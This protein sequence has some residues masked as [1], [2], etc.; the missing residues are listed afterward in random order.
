VKLPDIQGSSRIALGILLIAV[1]A[2][3]DWSVDLNLSFGFLYLFPMLLLGT[4][5]TRWQVVI[6]A[7]V[8][9]GLSDVFDPF[10]FHV[11]VSGPQDILVF[12][13]L[14]GTG[15]FSY[16]VTRSRRREMENLRRVEAEATARRQAEEQLEFIIESSPA[17]ILTI[18]SDA[19]VLRANSAAHRLLGIAF[20]ALPGRLI[21]RYL[22]A[23]SRVPFSGS[24][25]QNFRTEMQ[26]RGER[27]DGAVFLANVFFSTYTT[28]AGPRLAALIVDASE[29]LREREEASLEQMMAGSRIL[30]GAVSHEVRN[31]CGAIAVI[32]ENL[33]RSGRLQANKD[34]EALG[35]LVET[36]N[37]IASLELKQSASVA[38]IGGIDLLETLDD[39]RIVLEP[40][41]REAGI[42]VEWEV[43]AEL[44][45]V[46]ADR[47]SL[48][49]VLLNLTKN[50]ERALEDADEKR[51]SISVSTRGGLVWIRV[52]DSGPG[53]AAPGALFQPF[54]KGAD[55]TGLGL[56]LSRAFMRSFRG[57]LRHDAAAPGCCFV[58][59]LSVAGPYESDY[60]STDR[61]RP[62]PAAAAR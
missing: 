24:T 59:E 28:P 7:V 41:C 15:L 25:P 23:L 38:Q 5:L 39:L 9:T 60:G 42:T 1:I 26:C 54:Q 14:A 2:I 53:I 27:E 56:Y 20:G 55:S 4:A 21:G 33:A 13:A 40:Y 48:L 46:W 29:E 37:K 6:A 50:S 43:P 45:T 17:A 34:F 57:E 16:E 51:I 49:Q 22:P 11:L 36:L 35:A 18:G 31:V 12:T 8:C 62:H 44:P 52:A 61:R 58:I 32:Y 19:R 10:T 47:H 3:I 30:V